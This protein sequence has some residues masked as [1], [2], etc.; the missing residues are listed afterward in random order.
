MSETRF[1]TVEA[2]DPCFDGHF[3]GNPLVPGVVILDLVHAELTRQRGERVRVVGVPGVKFL[4]PLRPDEPMHIELA[5]VDELLVNF[6]C[7][8]DVQRIAEGTLRI[9]PPAAPGSKAAGK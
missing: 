1:V 3:P 7:R 4:R 2:A 6:T 8:V 9:A 5:N